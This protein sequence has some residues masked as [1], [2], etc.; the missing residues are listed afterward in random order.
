MNGEL[1]GSCQAAEEEFA[2]AVHCGICDT[3]KAVELV[4][5]YS[6]EQP[7]FSSLFFFFFFGGGGTLTFTLVTAN[8]GFHVNE[9][10]TMDHPSFK[11]TFF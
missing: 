1:I 4:M 7:P 10:L 5:N 11:I 3:D 8:S 9:P 6:D 2:N